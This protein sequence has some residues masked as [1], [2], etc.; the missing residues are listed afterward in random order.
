MESRWRRVWRNRSGRRKR[1][2][3]NFLFV[4]EDLNKIFHRSSSIVATIMSNFSSQDYSVS[5]K[6]GGIFRVDGDT[7]FFD[8]SS[9][10][11]KIG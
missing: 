9:S 11:V 4:V 7:L 8:D 3:R 2:R 6:R 1:I 10:E 5:K